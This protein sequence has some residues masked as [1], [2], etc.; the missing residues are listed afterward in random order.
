MNQDPKFWR[1]S[2]RSALKLAGGSVLSSLGC[3]RRLPVLPENF[4]EGDPKIFTPQERQF[5]TAV[6]SHLLPSEIDSPGAQDVHATQYLE[7]ALTGSDIN[8]AH[9]GQIKRGIVALESLSNEKNGT[10]FIS[11]S[12]TQ[13]EDLLRDFE[14]TEDG[15]EW[16]RTVMGYTIEAYLGD[17]AYGGNTDELGWRATG[18]SPGVPRPIKITAENRR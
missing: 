8:P 9:Q 1:I 4:A 3:V 13:R 18:H 12:T 11:L 6:Q 2:R 7:L 5:L 15:Y 16:L 14:D 17:P 10:A